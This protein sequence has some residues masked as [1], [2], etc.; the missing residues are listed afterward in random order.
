[1]LR[2]NVSSSSTLGLNIGDKDEKQ[3]KK[4]KRNAGTALK[5][6]DMVVKKLAPVPVLLSLILLL[7]HLWPVGTNSGYT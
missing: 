6:S 4:K 7:V 2:K 1:M 3:E 5:G